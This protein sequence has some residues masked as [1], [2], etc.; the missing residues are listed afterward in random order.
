[1]FDINGEKVRTQVIER[2]YGKTA[3]EVAIGG[4]LLSVSRRKSA[5]DPLVPGVSIAHPSL[6]AGTAGCIV[7]DAE[8]ATLFVLYNWHV[9]HSDAGSIGDQ[10]VQP[11]AAG[12]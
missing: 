3:R 2:N 10:I 7:Y 6:S 9:L 12:T 1:M 4:W 8:H 5:A 11:G